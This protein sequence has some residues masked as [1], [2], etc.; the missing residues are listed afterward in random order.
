[1]QKFVDVIE[2]AIVRVLI[3]LLLIA[4]I[5]GTIELARVL[6]VELIAP[7]YFLI[8]VHTLFDAFSLFLVI[9]IGIELL[10]S[11][12]IYLSEDRIRPEVVVQVAVI[13]L[14]NKIITLDLKATSGIALVGVATLLMGLA[15]VH[16]VF[17]P[18]RLVRRA[19]IPE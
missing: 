11:M 18:G 2:R 6:L 10:R 5:L 1:M 15:A 7:P 3:V 8:D 12:T 17:Q 13:A 4:I 9:L 19:R 14:C 16:F